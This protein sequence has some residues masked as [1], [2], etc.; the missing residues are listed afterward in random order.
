MDE[1]P[2]PTAT[3]SRG[4]AETARPEISALREKVTERV[5]HELARDLSDKLLER[6]ERIVWEVVPD[7]AEILISQEIDRIRAQAESKQSS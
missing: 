5:A 3:P 6:I 1:E 7:L 4:A 2:L